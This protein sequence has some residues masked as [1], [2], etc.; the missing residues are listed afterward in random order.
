MSNTAIT[1]APAKPADRGVKVGPFGVPWRP[2]ALA[3]SLAALALLLVLIV[4]GVAQGSTTLAPG[5]VIRTLLG[6]GTYP[7]HLIVFDLRLPRVLTGVLVGICLGVAGALTQT[8]TNNPLATPDV[9]GVTAGASSGAVAAILIGGGSFTV[10]NTLLSSGI[11]VAATA[12]ALLASALVYGLGWRNGVDSYRLILVGIG[13]QS[14]LTALTSY[15]LVRAQIQDATRAAAWLVGSLTGASWTS[16][17]PLLIVTAVFTPIAIA[18]SAP[19]AVA[20]LGDETATSVGLGVQRH[21]LLI[22]ALAVILT[23]AAVAA[24]GPIGFVAFVVPQIALRTTGASRPP[25]IASG[26]LGAALVIGAD[27]ASRTLFP[28]QIPVGLLTTVVGAPYLIWL[29]IR[30]RKE[31]AR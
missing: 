4:A 20:Q 27:L 1:P 15:L 19:L 18:C 29:L 16:F 11:P 6:G 14:V 23:G 5:D 7:Q 9:I 8:F 12:G 21:R 17:W 26:L 25:I 22:I 13:V 31:L 2:R 3:T 28:Y 10:T 24:A 30:H